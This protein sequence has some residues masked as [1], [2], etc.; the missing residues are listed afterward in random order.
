MKTKKR[1]H[2]GA[3]RSGGFQHLTGAHSPGSTATGSRAAACAVAGSGAGLNALLITVLEFRVTHEQG[4]WH[5][6]FV[7]GPSNL[8]AGPASSPS[9]G[10]GWPVYTAL[11]P[12]PQPRQR[13]A[14]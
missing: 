11:P 14:N 12:P 8:A 10:K 2:T 1:D 9:A 7:L 6:H 5:F 3:L 13:G 4:T